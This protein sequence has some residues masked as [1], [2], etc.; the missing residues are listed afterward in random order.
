LPHRLEPDL[1]PVDKLVLQVAGMP[2]PALGAITLVIILGTFLF[3]SVMPLGVAAWAPYP[4]AIVTAY[5]WKG[6]RAVV[7]IAIATILLTVLGKFISPPPPGGYD[8]IGLTN[9]VFGVTLLTLVGMLCLRLDKREQVVKQ[10]LGDL[11]AE[12]SRLRAVVIHSRHLMALATPA[13]EIIAMSGPMSVVCGGANRIL[14]ERCC[15]AVLAAD[16]ARAAGG[17]TV[18]GADLVLPAQKDHVWDW[19]LV[20]IRDEAGA[21]THLL[22]EAQDVT[23]RARESEARLAVY[24]DRKSVV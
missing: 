5:W 3:D 9:R 23:I 19:S 21:V 13:G 20:P 22:F 14:D 10:V 2:P 17:V 8:S 4:V 18:S 12:E 16:W 1:S 11:S 7:P 6:R 24:R 15:G